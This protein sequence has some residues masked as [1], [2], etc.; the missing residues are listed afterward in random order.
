[1]LTP[2]V[3]ATYLGGSVTFTCTKA[4]ISME[5]TWQTGS[6]P[7][8]HTPI[9]NNNINV[10]FE[11]GINKIEYNN[12]FV[13][14]I[15]RYPSQLDQVYPSNDSIILIQGIHNYYYILSTLLYI[16]FT[17]LLSS[18]EPNVIQKDPC[19]VE[20]YWNPPFTLKGVPI[21]GYNINITNINTTKLL[22]SFTNSSSIQV[23]LGD[24]YNI[25]IAAVN[26]AGEGNK[27]I[28]IINSTNFNES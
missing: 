15:T 1:M 18:I 5:T 23:P 7:V 27:S 20:V 19:T 10:I 8:H 24:D 26:G 21:L 25:S 9:N 28:I 4:D 17:G 3:A 6:L 2:K 14:C 16:Q 22:P 13:R 11:S 12:T